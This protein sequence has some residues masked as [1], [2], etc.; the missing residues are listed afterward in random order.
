MPC[1]SPDASARA[2]RPSGLDMT[3]EMPELAR[4]NA[5]QAGAQNVEFLRG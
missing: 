3:E 5:R 1:R 2:A 4:A